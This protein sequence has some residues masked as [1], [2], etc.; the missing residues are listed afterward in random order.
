MSAPASTSSVISAPIKKP[1][2]PRKPKEPK[3]QKQNPI[4]ETVELPP[5]PMVLTIPAI[6]TAEDVHLDRHCVDFLLAMIN[7]RRKNPMTYE[8]VVEMVTTPQKPA[9]ERKP[10]T[11]KKSLTV[12]KLLEFVLDKHQETKDEVSQEAIQA[13]YA[14]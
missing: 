2:A 10:S 13:G 12:T 3:A 6:T 8:Q 11:K 5:P 14:D 4:P 1:R 9:K 7:K